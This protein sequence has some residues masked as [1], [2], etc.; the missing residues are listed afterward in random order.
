MPGS[1]SNDTTPSGCARADARAP[2]ATAP[3]SLADVLPRAPAGPS[4]GER[5]RA[6]ADTGMTV[7][8]IDHD[9]GLVL[10]VCDTIHVLDFG[11]I[12]A[13]GTPEEIRNNPT[14]VAA[15]LGRAAETS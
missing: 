8:L 6:I 14:V 5:L 3:F 4:L 1:D 7:F 2:R 12:I 13:S 15:Y 9:M 10:D 11:E